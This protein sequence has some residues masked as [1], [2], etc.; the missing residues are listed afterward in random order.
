MASG[1]IIPNIYIYNIITYKEIFIFQYYIMYLVFKYGIEELY[2][3]YIYL[4]WILI[5]KKY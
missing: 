1:N 4:N 2:L 3:I 5:Q